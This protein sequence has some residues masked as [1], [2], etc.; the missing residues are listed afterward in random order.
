MRD[1]TVMAGFN[2][3]GPQA[4]KSTSL[5][6]LT[7]GFPISQI[8]QKDRDFEILVEITARKEDVS[9]ISNIQV[10]LR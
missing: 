2:T 9:K 3:S 7:D 5:L 1:E 8:L 4:G 6:S 10:R